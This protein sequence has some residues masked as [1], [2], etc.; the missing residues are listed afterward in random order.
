MSDSDVARP[1]GGWGRYKLV[2]ENRETFGS[3]VSQ[4]VSGWGRYNKPLP[5][6]PMSVHLTLSFASC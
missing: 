5:R 2:L 1:V 3:D 6:L 4:P